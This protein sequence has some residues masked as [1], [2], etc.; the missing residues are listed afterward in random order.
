M[1]KSSHRDNDNKTLW[2]LDARHFLGQALSPKKHTFFQ[3]MFTVL[4]EPYW[5]A[6]VASSAQFQLAYSK[7]YSPRVFCFI[8]SKCMLYLISKTALWTEGSCHFHFQMIDP[9]FLQMGVFPQDHE[10][11][12][13]LYIVSS[14]SSPQWGLLTISF[15]PVFFLCAFHDTTSVFFSNI[16]IFG[17]QL[18]MLT[19]RHCNL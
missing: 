15:L 8:I 1:L 17:F 7:F 4:L 16:Q 19:Q 13:K 18:Y 3:F 12:N 11:P 2:V 9:R 5:D 10:L 14:S 6:M